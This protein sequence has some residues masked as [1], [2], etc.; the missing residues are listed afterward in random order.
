MG[1][2]GAS[3]LFGFKLGLLFA[4]VMSAVVVALPAS[5]RAPPS[6]DRRG[7]RIGE[8]GREGKGGAES[9]G[10]YGRVLYGRV[11]V[12]SMSSMRSISVL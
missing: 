12:L 10:F 9:G 1:V 2:I 5:R 8:C 7:V 11:R 3:M 4:S 6:R